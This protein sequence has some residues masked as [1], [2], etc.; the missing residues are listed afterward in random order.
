MK[1]IVTFELEDEDGDPSHE[2]GI[3]NEQYEALVGR[4]RL[5]DGAYDIDVRRES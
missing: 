2:T 3:T 5:P 1:I 4:S